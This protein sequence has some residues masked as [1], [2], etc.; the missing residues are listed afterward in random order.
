MIYNKDERGETMRKTSKILFLVGGILAL[1]LSIMWL[2]FGI[3]FLIDA[4]AA[5]AYRDGGELDPQVMQMFDNWIAETGISPT[6]IIILFLTCGISSIVFFVFSI[7]AAVLSFVCQGKDKPSL[8]LLI[9]T[10]AISFFG[11]TAASVAGG[12]L[13]IIANGLKK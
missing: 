2:V 7:P 1:L 3:F 10:T 5:I 6:E 11:G 4:G 13:G 8:S 9:I 12:V